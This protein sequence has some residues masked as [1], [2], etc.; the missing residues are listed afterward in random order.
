MASVSFKSPNSQR[1]TDENRGSQSTGRKKSTASSHW[2]TLTLAD[3][4]MRANHLNIKKK[5]QKENLDTHTRCKIPT[6]ES[7][8]GFSKMRLE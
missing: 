7:Q 6:N 2:I 8:I 3:E 4:N 1:Q 5:S